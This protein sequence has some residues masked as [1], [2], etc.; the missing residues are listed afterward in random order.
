MEMYSIT[1]YRQG[2]C[3]INHVKNFSLE[4]PELLLILNT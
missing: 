4:D 1:M 2:K 3:I